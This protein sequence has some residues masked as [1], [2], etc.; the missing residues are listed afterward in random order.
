MYSKFIRAIWLWLILASVG[1]LACDLSMV[2]NLLGLGAP[3]KPKVTILSPTNNAQ[4]KEG[5]EIEI[6]STSTDSKG[7][8]RVELLVDG[9]TVATTLSP[10]PQGQTMFNLIQRWQATPGQHTL[11]VRAYNVSGVASDPVMVTIVVVPAVAQSTPIPTPVVQ[12]PLSSPSPVLQPTMTLPP[13]V[14]TVTRAPTR[15]PA[16]PTVSAPPGVYATAIRL[17]PKDPKRGQF[18]KFVVTF[19]NTTGTPQAYR[20]RIRIFEPD[21]RNSFGDTAPL[22]TTFPVGQSEHASAENW[23]VAGAGDCMQFF[24]RVFW[25]DPSTR[26]ET[27]FSKP[28]GLGGPATAFQV[29]P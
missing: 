16:S 10:V 26:Q 3:A 7:V 9:V 6:Q 22:D 28:D 8:V 14:P 17:E 27:E 18:V 5:E 24:A 25:I 29:C 19:L 20:W 23:R 1:V 21:K 11:S 13:V 4:F 2:T 15:P 12:P